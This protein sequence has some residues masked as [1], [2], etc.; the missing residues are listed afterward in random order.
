[1]RMSLK[2]LV[3]VGVS[4]AAAAAIGACSD[5]TI[6]TPPVDGS[7]ADTSISTDTGPKPDVGSDGSLPDT[8]SPDSGLDA[9]DGFDGFV[10]YTAP[11]FKAAMVDTYC[12]HAQTACCVGKPFDLAVCKSILNGGFGYSTYQL[13]IA[14]VDPKNIAVDILKAN[15]CINGIGSGTCQD[16]TIPATELKKITQDCFAALNG[17]LDIDD[18]CH[19]DIECKPGSYCEGG[20]NPGTNTYPPAGGTCKAL[21]QLGDACHATDDR[22]GDN[23]STRGSGDSGR[24]CGPS[25][26]CEPLIANDGACFLDNRCAS[27]A[28]D[29]ASFDG[30]KLYCK[31]SSTDTLL[32]TYFAP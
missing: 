30:T 32:C 9:S 28:C 27:G 17:K 29:V 13:D 16:K 18:V 25:N 6:V 10:G 15:A 23:C 19:A 31:N 2:L 3:G 11:Q 20:Y 1:M 4:V 5:S 22:L 26:T 21:K 24:Y 14:N 12:S 7:V 8:S